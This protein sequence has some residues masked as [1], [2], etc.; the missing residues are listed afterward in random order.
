[1][2][3]KGVNMIRIYL[4]T[5]SCTVLSED[6]DIRRVRAGTDELAQIRVTH[7]SHLDR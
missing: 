4:Q 5:A 1:M 6:A 3:E 7:V 2:S